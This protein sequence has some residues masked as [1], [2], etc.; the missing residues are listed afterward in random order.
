MRKILIASLLAAPLLVPAVSPAEDASIATPARLTSTGVSSARLVRT[1]GVAVSPEV[2]ST[3]PPDAKFVLKATVDEQGM[4]ENIT[5]VKSE[6]P[7]LDASVVDAVK[8]FRWEPAKLDNK[9]VSMPLTL[10]VLI[11][12]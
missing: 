3:L 8:Q 5:V 2:A 11:Q 6:N 12:H 10:N 9:A 4:A 1:T 7:T